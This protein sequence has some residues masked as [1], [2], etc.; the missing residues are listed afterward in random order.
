M[1]TASVGKTIYFKLF[2]SFFIN[3][4]SE[5]I[6]KTKLPKKIS[7]KKGPNPPILTSGA[8]NSPTSER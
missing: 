8:N 4:I 3:I 2:F 6:S 1:I 7:A 5:A